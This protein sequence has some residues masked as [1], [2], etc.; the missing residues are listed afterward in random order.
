MIGLS[1]FVMPSL[2]YDAD[3]IAGIPELPRDHFVYLGTYA[4]GSFLVSFAVLTFLVDFTQPTKFTTV[5]LGLMTLVWS[6]RF[7]LELLYPVDLSLFILPNPHPVLL[8]TILFI[9]ASYATAFL[10]FMRD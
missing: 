4:I 8:V 6:I 7:V 9:F 5:F 2:G 3:V 10:R 1:H